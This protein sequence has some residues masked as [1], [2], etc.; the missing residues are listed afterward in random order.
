MR[1]DKAPLLSPLVAVTGCPVAVDLLF[2]SESCSFGVSCHRSL[3]GSA[4]FHMMWRQELVADVTQLRLGPA[5]LV[6]TAR[7]GEGGDHR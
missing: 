7:T 5:T 3:H 4:L 6:R 2:A 1:Q